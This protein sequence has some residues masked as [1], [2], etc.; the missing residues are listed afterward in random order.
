MRPEKYLEDLEA[1][2]QAKCQK[3]LKIIRQARETLG[4]LRAIADEY[5]DSADFSDIVSEIIG[6]TAS[7]VEEEQT[8]G[9]HEQ[10]G[11]VEKF[12]LRREIEAILPE[13]GAGNDITQGGV[14]EKL[15]ERFPNH[16]A[17]I[18]PASISS[19]LR[20]I[21][22][23]GGLVLFSRGSGSEPNRYRLPEPASVNE[24]QE[25]LSELTG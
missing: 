8:S 23:N 12:S 17:S 5:G 21:E 10:N 20:R 19:S 25:E 24:S 1:K 22:S 14:R 13:F 4:Q 15:L 7:R 9:S 18:Q 16:E 2:V 3:D 11:L 6:K